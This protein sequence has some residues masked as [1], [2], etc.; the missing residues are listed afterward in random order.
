MN[1]KLKFFFLEIVRKN[2]YEIF[3]LFRK[4]CKYSNIYDLFIILY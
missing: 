4:Y 3:K 2:D 1:K